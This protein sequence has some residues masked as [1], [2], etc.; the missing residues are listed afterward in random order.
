MKIEVRDSG[1][2][3]ISGYVNA[4]ERD[5]RILPPQMARGATSPFVEKVSAGAFKRALTRNPE[6]R[7]MLDHQRYIDGEIKLSEDSIGLHAELTTSDDEVR[8][9]AL[10]GRLRGWSFGFHG[11][12]AEWEPYK[13][14]IQRRTLKDFSLDE[15]SILTRTPAYFGTSVEVRSMDDEND[16]EICEIRAMDD[17]VRELVTHEQKGSENGEIRADS[18][19]EINNFAAHIK[20]R[21]QIIQFKGGI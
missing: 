1:E 11:A 19:E 8:A 15:V 14:G 12:V 2:V 9:A 17:E 4:V 21:Q 7:A 5:S 6:T 10:S 20:R 18:G 16:P 13:D 3:H